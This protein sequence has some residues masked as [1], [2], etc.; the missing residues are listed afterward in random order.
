MSLDVYL[1]DKK[2]TVKTCCC[3]HCDNEHES[4]YHETLYRG[5]ITHNLGR[6]AGA[7]G[8]YEA[9]WRPEEINIQYAKELILIL[10]SGLKLL[11]SD[12]KKFKTFDSENGWGVYDH[13][14]IFVEDYLNACKEFPESKIEVCR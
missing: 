12:P 2:E 9:L 11:L 6:M 4:R 1:K 14:I 10:E 7:A 13:F 5:N 8:I 3:P